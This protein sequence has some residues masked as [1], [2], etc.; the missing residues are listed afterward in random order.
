MGWFRVRGGNPLQGTVR[1]SGA[2]NAALKI[3]A[4]ALL[5]PGKSVIRNVPAIGDVTSMIGVLEAVGARVRWRAPGELEV[6]ATD[7]PVGFPPDELVR[8]MRASVQVMGPLLAR[9]GRVRV[10]L[11]GGCAIGVRPLDLHLKGLARLGA[12]VEER[13]GYIWAEA[14]TLKGADIQLDL[15]S[16]G[17]TEN[18]MTCAVLAQ[19]VTVIRNAAREPEVV[20]LA[21]CLNGMGARIRGAGTDVIEIEGVTALRPADHTVIPDRIEAGTFLAAVGAAGGDVLVENVIFDHVEPIVAKLQ[22]AGVECRREGRGGLRVRRAVDV[23]PQP[24]VIRT[25]PH[26]GF[27]TDMQAQFSPIA[28][29]GNGVSIITERIYSSRFKYVD[30]LRRMGADIVVDGPTAVIRGVPSLSGAAV[31][32][33]D[34]RAGA[35][36]IIAGL[37]AHGESWIG[38]AYH[39]DRGYDDFCHKLRLLGADVQRVEEADGQPVAAARRAHA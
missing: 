10:S 2:K 37:A 22:E 34:L 35:A 12:T 27:P 6:D 4:A 3:M 14:R 8:R 26:P 5:A 15:P 1:V 29:L 23:R 18:L 20:D 13:H 31:E 28:A 24:F 16:V 11:P 39:I 32:A 36:L 7:D 30:E 25:H 33:P 38:G 17:A 9:T 21:R 19:G